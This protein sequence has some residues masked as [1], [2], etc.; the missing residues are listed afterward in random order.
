MSA[1]DA[2]MSAKDATMCGKNATMCANDAT[3]SR[4]C[5]PGAPRTRAEF[6]HVR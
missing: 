2:I 5:M 6:D 3:E 4:R 1:K